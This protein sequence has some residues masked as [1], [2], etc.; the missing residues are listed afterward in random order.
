MST[1]SLPLLTNCPLSGKDLSQYTPLLRATYLYFYARKDR[2]LDKALLAGI[3]DPEKVYF[4]AMSMW[5]DAMV[6]GESLSATDYGI[7]RSG[8]ASAMKSWGHYVE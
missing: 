7:V 8:V 5:L 2:A 1:S 6:I 3:E 4:C